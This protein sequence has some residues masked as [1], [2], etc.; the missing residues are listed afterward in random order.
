VSTAPTPTLGQK[1]ERFAHSLGLLLAY[2]SK[3]GYGIRLRELSRTREQAERNAK[4]GVGIA[5]SI[6][7]DHL[8]I[9]LYITVDG[10]LLWAGDP[11]EE[12]GR[13]W[14]GLSKPGYEHCWGGDFTRYNDCYH[15]SIAHGGRK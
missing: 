13:F 15:F 10:N 3:L 7:C 8:A 9:D 14:K 2:A 12:L 1:Q 11:Y 5:N 4:A 6:H